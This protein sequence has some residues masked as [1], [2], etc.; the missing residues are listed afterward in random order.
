MKSRFWKFEIFAF[1]LAFCLMLLAAFDVAQALERVG[2]YQVYEIE[3]VASEAISD[4]FATCLLQMRVQSPSG[5]RFLVE[6]FFDGDGRGGQEGKTWKARLC[7][8]EIGVWKWET[9]PGDKVD[10]RLIGREGQFACIESSGKGGVVAKGKYFYWQEGE[11]VYLQGNFLDFAGGMPSTHV[12]MSSMLTD[13]Q[14]ADILRRQTDFHGCNKINV[15]LAN[16][17]DYEGEKVLPWTSGQNGPNHCIMDIARWR[18]FDA[19]IR[20]LKNAGLVVELWFFADDSGFG[21]LSQREKN[22]LFRYAMARTSAF[23]HTMYVVCLE[24]QEGWSKSSVRSSGAYIQ[25]HNPWKRLV[26]VHGI[27]HFDPDR[28]ALVHIAKSFI[29]GGRIDYS[30]EKWADFAATQ[31]GN[32][33]SAKQVNSLALEMHESLAIPHLSEEFGM[34]HANEDLDL[35]SRMW[36]NFCGGAAG[37]GTG[38]NIKGLMN[39]IA[40]SGIP[41]DKMEPANQLVEA[42][43]KNVFCLADKGRH[44]LVY[45]RAGQFSLNVAGEDLK[46]YWCQPAKEVAY[47]DSG[48]PVKSGVNRFTPPHPSRD[49][50]LWVTGGGSGQ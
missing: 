35:R 13:E 26:S 50:V 17:G 24:W 32:K 41:F 5:R 10:K 3:F 31:A 46:G 29:P 8:D 45:T 43:D 2:K 15:Y 36:A 14:R 1:P 44:Y 9:V 16:Y 21:H 27:A 28:N 42:G 18:Q 38:S 4:P 30:E 37:G 7:P 34:L 12:F 48:F 40:A 49:W 6:G 39:F 25:A 20:Q 47:L 33:A 11:P 23:S 22:C 19:Y